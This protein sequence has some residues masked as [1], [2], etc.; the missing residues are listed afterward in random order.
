MSESKDNKM[1]AHQK[2]HLVV[3]IIRDASRLSILALVVIVVYMSL[4]AHYRAARAMEDDQLLKGFSGAVLKQIHQRIERMEDPQ[5]FLDQY[6]GTL[7]SMRLAGVDIS[8]PLAAAEMAAG[9]HSFHW[10]LWLS[11]LIP[12]VMTLVLGRVF[13]S[14]MC[15]AGLLF[16]WGHKLRKLLRL[17]EIKPG[18]V[19]FSHKNKY[20]VLV[21][22]LATT[23]VFALPVF[24]LI[25]PPA[26]VS[27]LVHALIFGTSV[28]GMLLILG[29]I[30]AIEVFVSPRWWCRTMCPGG[31]IY[32]MLS[33][34]RVVRVALIPSK[35][36][37]CRDC[38]PVCPM[39]I[40]PVTKSESIECD[41][42]GLCL[43]YCP[44]DA[45]VFTT[46]LPGVSSRKKFKKSKMPKPKIPAIAAS[47]A[48]LLA[49]LV[50]A[51][52]A[53]GHHIIGLPHY[54]YKENYPQAPTLE[55]PAST[56][57]FDLVMT[58]Y[59]GRPVPG[60]TA[61][62]AFYIKN[63][64][65]SQPYAQPVLV[66]ILQT[67]SFGNDKELI[68]TTEVQAFDRTHKISVTFPDDGQYVVELTMQ[69]EGQKEVIPFLMVAG[70]PS[71]SK[72]TLIGIAIGLLA[73]VVVIRAI[74][75]KRKRRENENKIETEAEKEDAPETPEPVGATK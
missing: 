41:S 56:G 2:K 60:E 36:T 39:G 54:A 51:D 14:W 19:Q 44:D 74:K 63:R 50:P 62:I 72:S 16:E 30:I 29:A 15:P 11:I 23:A 69:V 22:G 10:P 21:L 65:S 9:S 7:W 34:P 18:D 57:P 17:A 61:N 12:V 42:C 28:T 37:G 26:V 73:F 64:D 68:P 6:K 13:C 32:A 27:R 5:A 47:I 75:I 48:I 59:P 66:R 55:Y 1:T 58:S 52:V 8:D 40:Y 31:A 33:K 49:L 4:Y 70:N 3:Q 45:L 38:E 43:K 24:T 20:I 71:A 67:A 35:C 25:Y 46:G 53:R